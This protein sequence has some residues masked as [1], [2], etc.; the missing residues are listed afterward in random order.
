MRPV[1]R[2]AELAEKLE[3]QFRILEAGDPGGA[4][5]CCFRHDRKPTQF[6]GAGGTTRSGSV[7]SP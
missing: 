5:Q 4:A 3:V 1:G 2:R 6:P 7:G